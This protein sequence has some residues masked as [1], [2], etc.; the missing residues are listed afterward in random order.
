VGGGTF[1]P[2]MAHGAGVTPSPFRF[3]G[4]KG[5]GERKKKKG[6]GLN[7]K[8]KKKKKVQVLSAGIELRGNGVTVSTELNIGYPWSAGSRRLF[9]LGA[10][11]D[12]WAS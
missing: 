11:F 9:I 3:G 10:I 4:D 12:T 6:G 2:K 1:P 8:K 5:K 7:F